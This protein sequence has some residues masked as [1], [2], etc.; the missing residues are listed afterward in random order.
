M[1]ATEMGQISGSLLLT[2]YA[3]QGHRPR[4]IGWGMVF[5]G[6]S[7][8][9]AALP[10]FLYWRSKPITGL[11]GPSPAGQ[12]FDPSAELTCRHD[13]LAAESLIDCWDHT[14]PSAW[15]PV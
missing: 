12:L 10:H 1:S 7:S 11:N 5:F 2:Y 15:A 4:W 8:L 9:F 13:S 14:Q 6:V 3:G